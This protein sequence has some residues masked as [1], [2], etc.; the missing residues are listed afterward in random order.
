MGLLFIL[1]GFAGVMSLQVADNILEIIFHFKLRQ[2]SFL[3]Y[4]NISKGVRMGRRLVLGILTTL[5]PFAWILLDRHICAQFA[6][7]RRRI[8]RMW[9]RRNTLK[10]GLYPY[11]Q[12]H[13]VD[14]E[15]KSVEQK[16]GLKLP[17]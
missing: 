5:L 15:S 2:M 17:E 1:V 12:S 14:N 16:Q 9:S 7:A 6:M 8:R 3:S 11:I 4:V 10:R 13:I